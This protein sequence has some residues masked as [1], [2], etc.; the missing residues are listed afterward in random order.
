[1][2]YQFKSVLLQ[3]Q[4]ESVVVAAFE[5]DNECAIIDASSNGDVEFHLIAFNFGDED[6]ECLISDQFDTL[7]GALSG[8]SSFVEAEHAGA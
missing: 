7:S 2:A 5:G 1:M 4:K 6:A 8:L 3:E